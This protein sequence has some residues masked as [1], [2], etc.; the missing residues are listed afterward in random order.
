MLLQAPSTTAGGA[1]GRGAGGAS[2]DTDGADTDNSLVENALK[3]GTAHKEGTA[4]QHLKEGAVVKAAGQPDDE[5]GHDDDGQHDGQQPRVPDVK[6]H[7]TPRDDAG[8][9]TTAGGNAS[10]GNATVGSGG[11]GADTTNNTS[12]TTAGSAAAGGINNDSGETGEGSSHVPAELLAVLATLPTYVGAMSM[13]CRHA[14]CL[15]LFTQVH[16]LSLSLS[17]R[18]VLT[19]HTYGSPLYFPL[20]RISPPL[21]PCTIIPHLSSSPTYHHT[22]PIIIPCPYHHP[23]PPYSRCTTPQQCDE[24]CV[25]FCFATGAHKASR[26]RLARALT[27]IPYSALD[28]IPYYA[29]IGATLATV[30][31]DIINGGCLCLLVLLLCWCCVGV[32]LVLCV[33]CVRGMCVYCLWVVFLQDLHSTLAHLQT[34]THLHLHLPCTAPP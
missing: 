28:V 33:L 21:F 15:L 30:F 29:R 20:P 27:D 11:G 19:T 32:V 18:L 7:A 5:K 34:H 4:T 12:A 23:P 8:A 17:I 22:T 31:P 26:R 13:I 6:A 1:S 25:A 3:K 16:Y 10:A 2:G 14:V 24:L 9:G